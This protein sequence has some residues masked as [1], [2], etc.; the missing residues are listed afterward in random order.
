MLIIQIIHVFILL[1][2]VIIK[3]DKY[4]N[5]PSILPLIIFFAIYIRF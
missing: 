2:F 3:K 4:H 1:K 5:N